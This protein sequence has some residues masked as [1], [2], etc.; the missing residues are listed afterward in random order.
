MKPLAV[1]EDQIGVMLPFGCLWIVN[2]L[3]QKLP[4]VRRHGS[5]RRENKL[6]LERRFKRFSKVGFF[7]FTNFCE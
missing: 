5:Q 4:A 6:N 3:G 2:V 1:F 7:R